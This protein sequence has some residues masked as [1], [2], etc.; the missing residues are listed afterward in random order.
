MQIPSV[1][2]STAITTAPSNSTAVNELAAEPATDVLPV[3]EADDTEAVDTPAWDTFEARRH[4]TL[5]FLI[6]AGIYVCVHL[7]RSWVR[8]P[9]FDA[10]TFYYFGRE[11]PSW[12][13]TVYRFALTFLP[14][15]AWIAV[16]FLCLTS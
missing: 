10:D 9:L 5:L 7:C 6:F 14:V 12:F 8:Y 16:I 4:R 1:Y 13:E 3:V 11:G 2:E 15:A